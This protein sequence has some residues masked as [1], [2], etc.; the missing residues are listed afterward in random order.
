MTRRRLQLSSGLNPSLPRTC[1]VPSAPRTL[2][3]PSVPPYPPTLP[4]SD[5]PQVPS[6]PSSLTTTAHRSEYT[7]NLWQTCFL[8]LVLDADDDSVKNIIDIYAFMKLSLAQPDP[9]TE[10]PL[11]IIFQV[12]PSV[13]GA[14]GDG[15]GGNRKENK[16][17][18]KKVRVKEQETKEHD[19][20]DDNDSDNNNTSKFRTIFLTPPRPSLSQPAPPQLAPPF[21]GCA[22]GQSIT[23]WTASFRLNYKHD[24]ST[25]LCRVV[26]YRLV[27]IADECLETTASAA[28]P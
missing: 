4:S 22:A 20:D 19:K 15:E 26:L 11:V 12:Q 13:E 16:R 6:L 5:P 14:A 9:P 8:V 7:L 24:E 3:S 18:R 25:Y 27:N 21:P 23:T 28:A 10:P 2:H 1:L 17:K